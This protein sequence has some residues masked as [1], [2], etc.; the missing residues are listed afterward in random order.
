MA[1]REEYK[2]SFSGTQIDSS[3]NMVL[4]NAAIDG[5]ARTTL[6]TL[7]NAMNGMSAVSLG[8]VPQYSNLPDAAAQWSGKIVQYVGTT[9]NGKIQGYFYK[10]VQNGNSYGWDVVNVQPPMTVDAAMSNSSTNPVQNQVVQSALDGVTASVTAISNA[11]GASNGYASLD[12]NIKVV[13]AQASAHIKAITGNYTL[14]DGDAGTFIYANSTSDITITIP[15]DVFPIGTEIELCRWNSGEAI[16]APA[17][18]VTM[19]TA[20]YDTSATKTIAV[21][22]G[23]VGIKQVAS[24]TWLLSGNVGTVVNE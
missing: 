3:V 18:N 13:A 2:S 1:E 20:N 10:C 23:T 6:G 7:Q 19:Y 21:R 16:I 24:N 17:T 12:S 9:A 4:T 22:Y 14:A 15:K 8:A 11:R 5:V